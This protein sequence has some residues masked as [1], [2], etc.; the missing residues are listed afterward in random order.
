MQTICHNFFSSSISTSDDSI[1]VLRDSRA[2]KNLIFILRRALIKKVSW[3]NTFGIV[4][5]RLVFYPILTY[6]GLCCHL[7]VPKRASSCFV[8]RSDFTIFDLELNSFPIRCWKN[9]SAFE[10][11][12]NVQRTNRGHERDVG[13]VFLFHVD[14]RL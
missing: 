7:G 6:F 11:Q 12:L 2:G 3:W 4:V 5:A 10:V 9:E 14:L 1:E 13:F 8:S